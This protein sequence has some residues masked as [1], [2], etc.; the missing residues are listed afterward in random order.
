[1]GHGTMSEEWNGDGM[2]HIGPALLNSR[3]AMRIRHFG[4]FTDSGHDEAVD[5]A[6]D[7]NSTQ[8][9]ADDGAVSV[10]WSDPLVHWCPLYKVAR[11]RLTRSFLGL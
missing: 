8:G 4:F 11:F 1:M 7:G 9:N 3:V 2:A 6:E 5:E 10:Q